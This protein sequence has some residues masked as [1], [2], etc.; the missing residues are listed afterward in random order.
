MSPPIDGSATVVWENSPL[1]HKVIVRIRRK[2]QSFPKLRRVA[3][4]RWIGHR[5]ARG[6]QGGR[7]RAAW[8]HQGEQSWQQRV[9]SWLP[10]TGVAAWI[11][12]REQDEIIRDNTRGVLVVEGGPGTGKTAVAASC[13]RWV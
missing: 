5:S 3:T 1:F 12:Q 8:V 6:V 11:I 2:S 13:S 7:N 9:A 10:D 4:Y